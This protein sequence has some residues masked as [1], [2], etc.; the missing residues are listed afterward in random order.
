MFDKEF[1]DFVLQ[2]GLMLGLIYG[3]ISFGT[4]FMGVEIMVSI[5]T[6]VIS[7]AIGI[8]APIYYGVKWKQFKGGILDFKQAFIAI[9]L[10]YAISSLIAT[11]FSYTLNTIIDPELPEALFQESLRLTVSLM[12][13][14][15]APEVDIDEAVA[16]IEA[17]K[18][19]YGLRA[20]LKHYLTSLIFGAIVAVIG[21]AII[22]KNPDAF[23]QA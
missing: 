9:F 3:I 11:V 5:W 12:E 22:K 21:G 8:G 10:V 7:L 15:G 4:Y 19:V 17:E 20:E 1:K 16:Q 18:E 6:V 23:E 2:A 14:L 13:S